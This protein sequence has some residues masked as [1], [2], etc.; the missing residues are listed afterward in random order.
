VTSIGEYVFYNCRSLSLVTIPD[1]VTTIG[2]AVFFNCIRLVTLTIP[3]AVTAI[4]EW[5]FGGCTGLIDITIGRS[6]P[7]PILDNLFEG[8]DYQNCTLHVP[9]GAETLYKAAPGWSNFHICS[10]K[11]TI[12]T[13][14]QEVI[15]DSVTHRN[16]SGYLILRLG[17][18]SDELFGGTF[19]V[20]M[21]DGLKFDIARTTLLGSLAMLYELSITEVSSETWLVKINTKRLRPSGAA[22]HDVIKIAYT[23]EETILK[24]EYKVKIQDLEFTFAG[25]ATVREK[26]R[27]VKVKGASRK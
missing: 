11:G 19:L 8:I 6:R 1:S 20:A 23:A 4:G 13:T 12:V 10:S 9:Y 16:R 21:P 27:I 3:P 17:N 14:A 24:S 25:N 5:A 2:V 26:E 22:Y 15:V 18:L 7:L